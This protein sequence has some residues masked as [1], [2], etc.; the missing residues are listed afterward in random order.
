MR[1]FETGATRDSVGGK[2]DYEG[3]EHPLV[4][5]AFGKYMLS[6]QKQA[7]GQLRDSDNWQK[8]I[9]KPTY[10]K[11]LLRHA[12]DLWFLHRGI[13]RFDKDDG[14]ELTIEEVC[15]AIRFNSNGYLFEE[16]IGDNPRPKE[17]TNEV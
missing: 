12:L 1:N 13:P 16:L 4:T 14:H 8:G 17:E 11:S 7:D 15:C 10:I 9:P 5:E 2:P 6:H 3:Y